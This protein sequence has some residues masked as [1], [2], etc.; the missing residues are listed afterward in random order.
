MHDLLSLLA[1]WWRWERSHDLDGLGYPRECPS[2]AGYR[3]SRQYDSD[4]GA[5]EIDALGRTAIRVA[6]AVHALDDPWRTAAYILARNRA[7]GIDVWSSPRL[8]AD[9]T[10]RAV[11]LSET[12]ERLDWLL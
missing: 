9:K 4:S 2:T 5:D 6:A 12:V 10:E 1:L 11:I 3:P 7:T 8:P